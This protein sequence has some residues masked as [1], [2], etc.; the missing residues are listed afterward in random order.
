VEAEQSRGS[1]PRA[2]GPV[3]PLKPDDEQRP[4]VLDGEGAP[5]FARIRRGYS[6]GMALTIERAE[7]WLRFEARRDGQ[8]VAWADYANMGNDTVITHT[9]VMRAERGRGVGSELIAGV[10]AQLRREGRR[11][12]PGCSFV[13]AWLHT[14]EAADAD[15]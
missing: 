5:R 9:E 3:L 7:D 8:L 10:V 1:H 15:R 11:V 6:S 14:H 2:V 13:A 4:A 12:V